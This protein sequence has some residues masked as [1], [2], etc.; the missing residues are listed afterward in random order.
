[1]NSVNIWKYFYWNR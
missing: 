1:M